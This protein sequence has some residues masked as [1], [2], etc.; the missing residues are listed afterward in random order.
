MEVDW[1]PGR[2]LKCL[3]PNTDA[4]RFTGLLNLKTLSRRPECP[5]R[6]QVRRRSFLNGL[7]I[8]QVVAADAWML[9]DGVVGWKEFGGE[10]NPEPSRREPPFGP[11]SLSIP[12]LVRKELFACADSR[13]SLD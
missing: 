5:L 9:H 10:L 1:F 4:P 7:A 12:F 8:A 3:L 6:E 13:L 2:R 11:I